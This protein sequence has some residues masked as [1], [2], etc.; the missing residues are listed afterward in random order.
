MFGDGKAIL[1][2]DVTV[3]SATSASWAFVEERVRLYDCQY[4][5]DIS[6]NKIASGSVTSLVVGYSWI[7]S[8]LP[9]PPRFAKF[10]IVSML[11]VAQGTIQSSLP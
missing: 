4:L 1:R 2:T 8:P 9:S 3:I 7:K 6:S 5:T 11:L 10:C